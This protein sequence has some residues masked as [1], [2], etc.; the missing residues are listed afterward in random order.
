MRSIRGPGQWGST[1]NLLVSLTE[2][3]AENNCLALDVN[4]P[5]HPNPEATTE[6]ERET[7]LCVHPFTHEPEQKASGERDWALASYSAMCAQAR[8]SRRRQCRLNA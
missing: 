5:N 4:H 6:G 7:L 2:I 1:G 3:A 8:R